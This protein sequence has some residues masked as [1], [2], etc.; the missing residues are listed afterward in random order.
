MKQRKLIVRIIALVMALL[1]CISVFAIILQIFARA[2]DT[3]TM[4]AIAATGGQTS[5][6]PV[7]LG[8]AAV[9]VVIVCIVVPKLIKKK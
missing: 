6:L 3:T 7:F 8:L 4:A 2:A 5:K 1:M 9:L